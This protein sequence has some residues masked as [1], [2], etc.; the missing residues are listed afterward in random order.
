MTETKENANISSMTRE[1][2]MAA[3]CTV[4]TILFAWIID[5]PSK[6]GG[7]AITLAVFAVIVIVVKL[8]GE[9]TGGKT[10]WNRGRHSGPPKT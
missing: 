5:H 7:T 10:K 8:R 9:P 2:V 1:L 3:L 6:V 4:A